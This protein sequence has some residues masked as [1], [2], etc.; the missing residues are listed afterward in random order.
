[1]SHSTFNYLFKT[2]HMISNLFNVCLWAGDGLKDIS[3]CQVI[4]NEK[5]F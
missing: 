1:M 4:L 3:F 2:V 5:M